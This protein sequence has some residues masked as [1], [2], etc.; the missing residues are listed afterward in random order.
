MY[1]LEDERMRFAMLLSFGDKVTALEPEELETR[2]T[3]IA[4]NILSLYKE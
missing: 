2:L 4:G 3:E 1:S